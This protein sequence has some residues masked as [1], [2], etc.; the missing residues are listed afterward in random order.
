[1]MPDAPAIS[2][3]L[4]ESR[5]TGTLLKLRWASDSSKSSLS[6]KEF[7]QATLDLRGGKAALLIMGFGGSVI[8]EKTTRHPDRK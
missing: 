8:R 5:A 3:V 7:L 1:M 2:T 6:I 4:P